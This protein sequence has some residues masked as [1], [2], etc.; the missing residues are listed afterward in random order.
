M[1]L[2]PAHQ[3][4]PK[5]VADANGPKMHDNDKGVFMVQPVCLCPNSC[6]NNDARQ[7]RMT[8][9]ETRQW[10]F[11]MRQRDVAIL[12]LHNPLLQ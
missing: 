1:L 12:E 5:T 3:H 7:M 9:Q 6:E 8:D 4:K 2:P 11:L 10:P